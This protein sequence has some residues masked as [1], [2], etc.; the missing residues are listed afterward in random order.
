M[1]SQKTQLHVEQLE[2]RTMLSH[3]FGLPDMVIAHGGTGQVVNDAGT[4]IIKQKWDG[5]SSGAV[6]QNFGST[7][8]TAYSSYEFDDFTTTINYNVTTLTVPGVELGTASANTAVTGEIWNGLP[9]SG[10]GSIVMTSTHGKEKANGALAINFGSQLL[11]A[12]S[13]WI[14]AFVTRNFSS[15]GQWF[16][17]RTLEHGHYHGSQEQFYNPGGGFGFGTQ[18]ING[19][20]IFG[21]A[22]DMA[23]TLK[24]TAAGAQQNAAVFNGAGNTSSVGGVHQDVSHHHDLGLDQAYAMGLM[25]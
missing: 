2:S 22:E 23:F 19:S 12:G 1:V 25:N 5:S 21:T 6:A 24:G 17:D 13:Y 15:G 7:G 4:R 3:G 14:T 8:L 20:A 10:G 11:P 16:W 18:P 9:G